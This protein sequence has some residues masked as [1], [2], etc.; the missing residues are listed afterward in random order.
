[1]RTEDLRKI[2]K[3]CIVAIVCLII[4]VIG[5]VFIMT[6]KEN[7]KNSENISI[8]QEVENTEKDNEQTA[9]KLTEKLELLPTNCNLNDKMPELSFTKEDNEELK[10]SDLKGKVVVMT[11]WASW[12]KHC[13]NELF[14]A[15]EFSNMLNK[16]KDVQFLLVDKLDGTKETKEQALNYLK[17]NNIPF[18]TV[19]YENLSAYK[20]LG[21]NVVPTTLIINKSGVLTNYYEPEIEDP[22]QMEALIKEALKEK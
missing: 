2:Q 18:K 22:A 9:P 8:A 13:K 1:M 20:S 3:I 11:F 12:C 15:E 4:V 17:D 7:Q 19:F 5:C 6:S 14:H 21:I 16:Y 10:L